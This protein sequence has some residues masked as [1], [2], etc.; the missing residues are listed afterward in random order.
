MILFN[1]SQMDGTC[2]DHCQRLESLLRK[3]SQ[4]LEEKDKRCLQQLLQCVQQL[5]LDAVV[6]QDS[7]QST[8]RIYSKHN[9]QI[10]LV[11]RGCVC[12]CMFRCSQKSV[13][14]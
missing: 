7:W 2:A 14:S 12:L 10:E 6:E 9:I 8:V 13:S 5:D 11:C 4:Q 1:Y 3:T